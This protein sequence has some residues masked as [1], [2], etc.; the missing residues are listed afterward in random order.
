MPTSY[1]PKSSMD[2]LKTNRLLLNVASYRLINF[3]QSIQETI[4]SIQLINLKSMKL[5]RRET[6]FLLDFIH[7]QDN[8]GR[9]IIIQLFKTTIQKMKPIKIARALS[10][11]V[12]LPEIIT[13]KT[14]TKEE[15]N[16]K[17]FTSESCKCSCEENYISFLIAKTR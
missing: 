7:R 6:K 3:G 15:R 14:M 1:C 9:L 12:Q 5:M 4:N 8:N 17:N 10:L 2:Q 13:E 16:Y 11:T